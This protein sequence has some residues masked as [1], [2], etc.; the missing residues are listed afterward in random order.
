[1]PT[2]ASGTKKKVRLCVNADDLGKPKRSEAFAEIARE[3][4][5]VTILT[6]GTIMP[7]YHEMRDVI[8]S[9]GALQLG[10]HATT[11]CEHGGGDMCFGPVTGAAALARA[12]GTESAFAF[13]KTS[14]DFQA[15][16]RGC[17]RAIRAELEAQA[18]IVTKALREAGIETTHWDNHMGS[19]Y[20][21]A[22]GFRI[23]FS[24]LLSILRLCRRHRVSF[25]M[26]RH[27]VS[28]MLGN[29]VLAIPEEMP[30]AAL[31]VLIWVFGKA[32]DL[33]GVPG[34]DILIP[35]D[36]EALKGVIPNPPEGMSPGQYEAF[37]VAYY[38]VYR[39]YVV[40]LLADIYEKAGDGWF[41]ETYVHPGAWGSNVWR[42]FEAELLKDPA[43]KPELEQIG[44]VFTSYESLG[45]RRRR[46]L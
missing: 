11:T 6:Q 15:K 37:R 30:F 3:Y 24:L 22:C 29:S 40:K 4:P 45:N 1:M 9:A 7:P 34:P 36:P 25:R 26:P 39:S 41:V 5:G 16:T 44:Y 21:I 28:E 17:L 38:P 42:L 8:E 19:M 12:D 46:N 33:F 32:A 35:P 31:R 18:E 43:L 14:A 2:A 20:G 13:H 10:V 27:A 23:R